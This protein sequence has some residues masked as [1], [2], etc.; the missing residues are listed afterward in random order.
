MLESF[1]GI[2]W[3]RE[4]FNELDWRLEE[5]RLELVDLAK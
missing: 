4:V 1:E 5:A 3:S 2:G